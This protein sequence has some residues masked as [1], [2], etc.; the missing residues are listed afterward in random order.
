MSAQRFRRS[1]GDVRSSRAQSF[2]LCHPE[3]KVDVGGRRQIEM[4]EGRRL[5]PLERESRRPHRGFG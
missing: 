5:Q 2:S 1:L 4:A 3:L